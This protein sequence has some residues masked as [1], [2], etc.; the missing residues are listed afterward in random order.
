MNLTT[1]KFSHPIYA[2][3]WN[4]SKELLDTFY[5]NWHE[6]TQKHL[7]QWRERF[8]AEV[9]RIGAMGLNSTTEIE[10]E[11]YRA[12]RAICREII[13][14]QKMWR[15]RFL[16]KQLG[17]SPID[18][19][20]QVSFNLVS[21]KHHL[22][23]IHGDVTSN[24]VS[25]QLPMIVEASINSLKLAHANAQIKEIEERIKNASPDE[26]MPLLEQQMQKI[27]LRKKLSET[28]GERVVNPI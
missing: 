20:R 10:N 9:Q 26:I 23:K 17:F 15:Q 21:T 25:T 19:V 1:S 4:S 18:E 6:L 22:S 12:N 5:R 24:F 8:Q 14:E 27:E 16:E 7:Q 2:A 28:L 13:D 11:E 3:I